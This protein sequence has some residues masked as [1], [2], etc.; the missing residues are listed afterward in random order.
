V[1]ELV[2]YETNEKVGIITMNRPEKLNAI[3]KEFKAALTDAFARADED[4]T[5]HV[6]ILRAE[7]RSFCVGYD[8]AGGPPV[9]EANRH[10]AHKW[11]A[12]LANSVKFEMI[13]W[14]MR[15]PVVAS[16]QGHALGGGCELAMFCD[17]TIAGNDA[18]FGEPEIHFSAAG[19][20]MVMPWIIGLKKARELLYTGDSIGADEALQLGMINRVVPAADLKAATLK[21]AQRVALIAPEALALTKLAINRG[22]DAGGFR[23]AMESGVDVLSQLYAADTAVGQEF[24]EIKRKQGLGAALKWRRSQFESN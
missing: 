6:V 23:Q 12:Q 10:V 19:P 8:I 2:L 14:Y 24:Q 4:T 7:G 16:V 15:K 9:G 21:Y 20:S 13:P 18:V 3:N 22:A 17:L 5:T 11:H 1:A